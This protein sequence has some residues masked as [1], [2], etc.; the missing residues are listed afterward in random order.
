[1]EKELKMPASFAEMNNDE[2]AYTEGGNVTVI[3][4]ANTGVV[5][6]RR[7][8]AENFGRF[9]VLRAGG[10]LNTPEGNLLYRQA[11]SSY[12]YF[13]SNLNLKTRTFS[14]KI[15]GIAVF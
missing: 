6:V 5:N 12:G 2:M 11:V 4:R 3:V 1:M 15:S 10:K 8:G 9:V 13:I 7:M 14:S